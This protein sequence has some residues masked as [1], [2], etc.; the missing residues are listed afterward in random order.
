MVTTPQN[1][2]NSY[3]PPPVR[4]TATPPSTPARSTRDQAL[5]RNVA[6]IDEQIDRAL[7]KILLS[8]QR[9]LKFAQVCKGNE[10]LFGTPSSALRKRV[11]NRRFHLTQLQEQDPQAFYKLA[12]EFGLGQTSNSPQTPEAAS[13]TFS[14]PRTSSPLKNRVLRD[15]TTSDS[16]IIPTMETEDIT[17]NL[18]RPEDNN[19]LLVLRGVDI[20]TGNQVV[21]AITIYKPL[22]DIQDFREKRIKAA[23]F[24]DGSGIKVCWPSIPAFFFDVERMHA[25]DG[26]H[27]CEPTMRS[28][29]VA[30]TAVSSDQNR[31]V[32]QIFIHFPDGITCNNNHFNE[33]IEDGLGL[34]SI[35]KMIPKVVT[36]PDGTQQRYIQAYIK[37]KVVITNEMTRQLAPT[38]DNQENDFQDAIE[39]LN[40][41]GV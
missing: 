4:P 12:Q 33:G 10:A 3:P 30:V 6:S 9:L 25:V 26:T 31:R 17:L 15:D 39:M 20:T 29:R 8:P 14:S 23:L 21:D 7:V 11:Q 19:G 37:W 1:S 16:T 27:V 34:K 35:F 24:E 41:L 40:N 28:H 36:L 2:Y 32:R 5:R 22:E 18:L 38:Q 13:P